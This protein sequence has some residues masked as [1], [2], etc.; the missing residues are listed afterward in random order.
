MSRSR[1]N[2]IIA[3]LG[4]T[5]VALVV[6]LLWVL[7]SPETAPAGPVATPAERPAPRGQ[8]ADSSSR[9]GAPMA[10]GPAKPPGRAR[11][12]LGQP[13][14]E[15]GRPVGPPDKLARIRTRRVTALDMPTTP[16]LFVDPERRRAFKAWWVDEVA[17]RV[18]IYQRLEPRDGY[19]G[20]EATRALLEDYYDSAE[21]R[22]PDETVDQAMA[23]RQDWRDHWRRFQDEYGAPIKTI[24]SRGGDPQHG[25]ATDPPVQPPGLAED[26]DDDVVAA[27][28]ADGAPPGRGPDDPGGTDPLD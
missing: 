11:N 21:P 25:Q 27:P 24:V 12:E 14:N 28:P 8:H 6:S 4:V 19:P 20:A 22:R 15:D 26:D 9:F 18:E 16:P 17:R 1:S 7:R 3:V 10:T 23:R 2:A 13:L 5:V